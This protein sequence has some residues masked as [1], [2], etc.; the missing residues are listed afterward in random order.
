MSRGIQY[1]AV[2]QRYLEEAISSVR[3]SLRYNRVPHLI[4]TDCAPPA[5][6]AG[7]EF[8]AHEPCGRPFADKIAVMAKSPFGETIQLDTDTHVAGDLTDLFDIVTRFDVVAAHAPGY[9]GEDPEV[10]HAFYE[11]N[12]GMLAFRGSPEVKRFLGDWRE[13]YLAWDANPPF[14]TAAGPPRG[15]QPALRRCLWKSGLSLYIVGPEYNYRTI[16]PGRLLG[17]VRIIHGR[18]DDYD[19]MVA[20]LNA[21]IGPRLIPILTQR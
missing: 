3:S 1:C 6:I 18:A 21:W 9:L 16:Q 10:P 19:A 5:P 13:T 7:V 12:S 2:G 17:P 15:D 8:R 20:Q 11:L 14:P 4:Y